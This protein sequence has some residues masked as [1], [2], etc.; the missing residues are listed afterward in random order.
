MRKSAVP[1]FLLLLSLVLSAS[2][3]KEIKP[4]FTLLQT[5][6]VDVSTQKDKNK[7]AVAFFDSYFRFRLEPLKEIS[8]A[9]HDSIYKYIPSLETFSPTTEKEYYTTAPKLGCAQILVSQFEITKN[10]TVMMSMDIISVQTKTSIVS[11]EKEF[12]IDQIPENL[13]SMLLKIFPLIKCPLSPLSTRFFQIAIAGPN[14]KSIK[15]LGELVYDEKSQVNPP[16]GKI[17]AEY[18]KCIQKDPTLLIA[19]NFCSEACMKVSQFEK[20][21]KYLKELLDLTPIHSELFVKLSDA[22][23]NSDKINDAYAVVSK[24]DQMGLVSVPYL[25]EKAKVFEALKQNTNAYKVYYQILQNNPRHKEALLFCAR[26]YNSDSKYSQAQPFADALIKIDSTNGYGYFEKGKSLLGLGKTDL[27]CNALQ[28]SIVLQPK[29]PLLAEYLGDALVKVNNHTEA[30]GWYNKAMQMNSKS[31][32]LLF[33][34]SKA[35]ENSN[36]PQEALSILKNN[37]ANYADDQQLKKAIGILE[38][39]NKNFTAAIEPLNKYLKTDPNDAEALITLGMAYEKSGQLDPALSVFQKALPLVSNKTDCN[40]SIA[41]IFIQKKDAASAQKILKVVLTQRQVKGAYSLMGDALLMS[42]NSKDA[43]YNYIK[44]RELHGNDRFIQEKISQLQYSTGAFTQSSFEFKRLLQICPEH[45]DARYFIAIVMLKD[46]NF[47]GAEDLLQEAPTFGKGTTEIFYSVGNEFFLKKKF[48]KAAEYYS[49]VI[50]LTPNHEEALRKCALSEISI[51]NETAGAERYIQLF[52]INNAKYSNLLAEAGHLFFKNG[53]NVN[54]ITTYLLFLSKGFV[55]PVVNAHYAEIEYENK[56]Y[57]SVCSILKNVSSS[58]TNDTKVL[59]ILSDSRC[60][61]DD[62]KGA[63][64][65]LTALL[66]TEK[67]NKL[68]LKL[69]A[70]SFEKTNELK[71]SIG[72]Y[73]QYL[74]LSR[75]KDYSSISFHLG[76]LYESNQMLDKAIDRYESTRKLYPED[77]RIHERLGSIYMNKSMWKQAQEVL[78]TA[79]ESP[80]AQPLFMKMLA[81]TFASK[82]AF[83][84]AIS[85]YRMYLEKNITDAGGWKDLAKVYYSRQNYPEA[86]ICLSKALQ[87]LPTDFEINSL[88]GRTYVESGDYKKAITPLGHARNQKPNDISTIELIASCYRNLNE[89]SSLTALLK[90]WITLD[91]KRYDIKVE[92]GSIYLNEHDI[93]KALSYLNDAVTFLPSEFRPHLLLAQAFELKGNDSLRLL[94]LEKAAKLG[95]GNWELSYQYARY[96]VSKNKFDEAEKYFNKVLEQKPEHAQSHFELALILNEKGN[97]KRALEELKLAINHDHSNPLFYSVIAYVYSLNDMGTAS[98]SAID[99]AIQI[100][101]QDPNMYYWIGQAYRLNNKKNLAFD[102]INKAL[103]INH[104]YAKGYEALGDL[105]LESFK[106]KDA[107][108]N[109]FLSWEKGGYNPTRALKLGNALTY[110]L[111]YNEAKGFYESI[112]NHNDPSGEAVYR[113]IYAYCKLGDLKNARKFQ[114][115]FKK[116]DAPWMQLAQGIVYETD[117]NSESALTA[118]SIASKIAPDNPLVY[119]GFGRIYAQRSQPDSSIA[120]F[121]NSL[122]DSLNMQTFIDLATVFQEKGAVDSALHYYDIVNERFP[123][124]P[125]VQIYIASLQSQRNNHPAAI[126]ALERGISYHPNDPM[127]HFLLGQELELSGTFEEAINEYQIS[128]KIGDGQPIEALRNIGTIYFQKLINDKKAKEYY[129]KYVKAGGNKNEIADAMKKLEKI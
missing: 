95:T 105:Y 90:E 49:K 46:G 8:T 99:T 83:D 61:T 58:N 81:Q 111:Q 37:I 119:S 47:D 52:A 125:W 65:L 32:E 114:K 57:S 67:N 14:Y 126:A 78:E 45:Q 18:E 76:Q 30:V 127:I 10:K 27:A 122:K 100:G 108:K 26:F 98:L 51:G 104:D 7:W 70:I 74:T 92:L 124:H 73:E 75:D 85:M 29:D 109:Y 103:Q 121:R 112:L 93:E 48:K 25:F 82:N 80:E 118:Y 41:R 42:N 21:S 79:L 40:M 31:V 94:H 60:Q 91:P 33:K 4:A 120:N 13:D 88:L 63:I 102:N 53:Q 44:E 12:S 68:V 113:T 20:A 66:T 22:Y 23:R 86:I 62:Y 19:H 59:L 64:P 1:L 43:L 116:D 17:A 107:S 69:A 28:K 72:F 2:P 87:L 128:L 16:L 110:N 36:N 24:F 129:K 39:T 35:L 38:F 15:Q 55:D 77:L 34:T 56:N 123:E 11:L 54:A 96:Y 5:L 84:K 106:F 117:N 6:P 115:F 89:T 71:K 50:D 3:K 9:P 97:S 101:S